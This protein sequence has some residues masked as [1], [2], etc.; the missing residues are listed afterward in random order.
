MNSVSMRSPKKIL[1][2]EIERLRAHCDRLEQ[3]V[4]ASTKPITPPPCI[5]AR[6]ALLLR[7]KEVATALHCTTRVNDGH[8][9]AYDPHNGGWFKV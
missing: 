2:S 7:A 9:E 3:Q 8:V 6:R 4:L 1:Y 5:S